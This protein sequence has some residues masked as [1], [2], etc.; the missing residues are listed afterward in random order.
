[1]NFILRNFF[2]GIGLTTMYLMSKLSPET[3]QFR[4][5]VTIFHAPAFWTIAGCVAAMLA[6]LDLML[7]GRLLVPVSKVVVELRGQRRNVG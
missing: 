1:M 6:G 5:L 7:A 4:D 2:Y 3:A